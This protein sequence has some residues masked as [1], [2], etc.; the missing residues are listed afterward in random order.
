MGKDRSRLSRIDLLVI[1][2]IVAISTGAMLYWAE[3]LDQRQF[4]Q[5]MR[6]TDEARKP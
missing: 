1:F 5:C 6:I 4:D 2:A 3:R